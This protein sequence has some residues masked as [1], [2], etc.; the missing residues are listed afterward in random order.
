MI[1]RIQSVYLIIATV[2]GLSMLFAN[3]ID[4]MSETANYALNFKGFYAITN[5]A[6]PEVTSTLALSILLFLTPL[7]SLVNIFLFKKRMIQIRLCAANIG[8]L[9]GVTAMIYYFGIV[10]MKELAATSKTYGVT[11]VFP[12]A[13]AILNFLAMRGIIKDEA[14]IKSMDRIR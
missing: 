12:I 3:Q 11:M 14:L 7:I 10:G 5:T 13:S 2:F 4:F 9:L 1:Q 6:M 8:L